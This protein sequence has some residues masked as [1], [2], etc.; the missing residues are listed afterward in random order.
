MKLLL[1][2][3]D[4]PH[5]H[6]GGLARHVLALAQALHAA[7]HQVDLLGNDAHQ[8]TDEQRGPGRFIAGLHG[9]ERGWGQTRLGVLPPW[10]LR[11]R[12][13]AVARAI[14]RHAPGYDLVHYHGHLPWLTRWLPH[15]L[16]FTQTRHDQGGDCLRATRVRPDGSRCESHD[17]RDCAACVTARPGPVQRAVSA[18]AVRWMRRAT[19]EAAQGHG[20][21][22]VAEMLR[23]GLVRLG[24]PAGQAALI[25]NAADRGPLQQAVAKGP[26]RPPPGPRVNLLVAAALFD[27]KGVG[28]LLDTLIGPHGLPPGWCL[29]VAGDGPLRVPLQARWA[30]PSVRFTGWCAHDQTLQ[31]MLDSHAVL[32]PSVC[33]EPCSTVVLEAL[34]LGRPVYAL[35]RGG[36]PALAALA[37]PQ[38]VPLLRLFDDLPQLAAALRHGPVPGLPADEALAA[39]GADTRAMAR[40]LEQHYRQLLKKA[41]G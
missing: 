18:H 23:A 1:V 30:G 14:V 40:Q 22:V 9:A 20:L 34:A 29:T 13:Q 21:V 33:D 10:A 36:T 28:P 15:G 38:A 2:T 41:V 37:G 32:L 27:Y 5:P 17:P 8:P 35:H 12:A 31:L 3:E 4:L 6:A 24:A 11:W 25:A 7:G 16:L 26:L 19:A 39:F